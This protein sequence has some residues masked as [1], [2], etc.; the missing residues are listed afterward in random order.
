MQGHAPESYPSDRRGVATVAAPSPGRDK[1]ARNN[2]NNPR[3]NYSMSASLK[4]EETASERDWA[5]IRDLQ[6]RAW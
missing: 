3:N 2:S 4:R 5:A 1:D 6:S